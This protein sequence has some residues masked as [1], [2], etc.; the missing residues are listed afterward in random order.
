MEIKMSTDTSHVEVPTGVSL[1]IYR[2]NHATPPLDPRVLEAM[3][4]YFTNKFG[5][6]ASRNHSFGWE[7]EQ[8]VETAREQI[9]S[10]SEAPPRRSSSPPALPRATTWPSRES[11]RCTGSAATTSSPR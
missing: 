4:P 10:R 1:P 8:A 6:A 3:M 9:A 5:N 7:A 11:P 2:D